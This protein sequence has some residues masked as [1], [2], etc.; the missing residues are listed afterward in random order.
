M[1]SVWGAGRGGQG[2]GPREWLLYREYVIENA[3]MKSK[4]SWVNGGHCVTLISSVWKD[5]LILIV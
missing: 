1:K 2:E 3:I 5:V 4:Q